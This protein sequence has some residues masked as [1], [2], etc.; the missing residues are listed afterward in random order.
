LSH[1]AAAL[2]YA[3]KRRVTSHTKRQRIPILNHCNQSL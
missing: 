1:S 3:V 2:N